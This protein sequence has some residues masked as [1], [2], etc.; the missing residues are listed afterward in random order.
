MERD[1]LSIV[2][3]ELRTPLT[4]I[5]TSVGALTDEDAEAATEG[6]P[7]RLRL[8]RNI[9]RSTDRLINLV[10]ESL[11]MARLRAG[12]VSLKVQVLNVG[13]LILEVAPQV[14]S[15]LGVRGQILEVD[16][17]ARDS[18]RWQRLQVLG[19]RRRLEQVL[20]NLMANANKYGPFGGHITV[21]ATP[22]N[23][24]VRIFVR[25]DGPGIEPGEQERIFEK[26]YQGKSQQETLKEHPES[27]G[28]GL[29]IARSIVELH[30]GYIGVQSRRFQGSTFYFV[31]AYEPADA[32][33]AGP[34]RGNGRN[35]DPDR[36]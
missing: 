35:E 29:A 3:H 7:T 17:P 14:R 9:G 18:A 2:S 10:S 36:G 34:P 28:L 16:L 23:G 5:K 4:A 21:G 24:Q 11:D 12:R 30:G 1:L 27:L 26:F 33:L 31:L 20:L 25:D 15:L 32:A 19:D 6:D 8:L 13:D 22:R